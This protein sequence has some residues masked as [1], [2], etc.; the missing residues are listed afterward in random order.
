[1][2]GATIRSMFT[3]AKQIYKLLTQNFDIS[4]PHLDHHQGKKVLK[5][6][7]SEKMITYC[8]ILSKI[9]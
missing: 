8:E 3:F 7:T 1:M 9:L 4:V 6:T 5:T 2:L